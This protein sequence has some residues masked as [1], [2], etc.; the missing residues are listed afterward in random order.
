VIV[1][2]FFSYIMARTSHT[3]LDD[4]DVHFV[5]NKQA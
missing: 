5:P 4:D 3:R 1:E 2:V